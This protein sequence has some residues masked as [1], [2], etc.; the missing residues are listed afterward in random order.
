MSKL[1]KGTETKVPSLS[2]CWWPLAILEKSRDEQRFH[3]YSKFAARTVFPW[4]QSVI[5]ADQKD[6]TKTSNTERKLAD[7]IFTFLEL[8]YMAPRDLRFASLKIIF[9]S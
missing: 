4:G 5:E 6:R 3:K 2:G 9:R 1:Q 8:C 7:H